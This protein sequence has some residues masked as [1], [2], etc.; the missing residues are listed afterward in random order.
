MCR[1]VHAAK[2][3]ILLIESS[4]LLEYRHIYIHVKWRRSSTGSNCNCFSSFCGPIRQ[5][6]G[7]FSALLYDHPNSSWMLIFPHP[8]DKGW[9]C[10]QSE[11]L[12]SLLPPVL[13]EQKTRLL[14]NGGPGSQTGPLYWG[15]GQDVWSHWLHPLVLPQSQTFIAILR[16][17][18]LSLW[19][20]LRTGESSEV[21]VKRGA[22]F[23][24]EGT[25]DRSTQAD[26]SLTARRFPD[27][28]IQI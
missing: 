1:S 26:V 5:Q 23:Q 11:C 16:G 6:D 17:I 7:L 10:C 24:D 9:V 2:L 13:V 25:A 8:D 15:E 3:K 21:N 4:T 27:A 14:H 19:A 22:S 20:H 28:I 12:F 18:F